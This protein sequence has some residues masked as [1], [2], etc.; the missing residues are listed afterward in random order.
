MKRICFILAFI[1]FSLQ[2]WAQFPPRLEDHFWRRKVVNR[3]DLEEKV[4]KPLV[5]QESGYYRGSEDDSEYAGKDG[6]ISALFSGLK[7]TKYM[8]YDPDTLS[9]PLSYQDVIERINR[10]NAEASAE[11]ALEEEGELDL[12]LEGD[13]G[14]F[15]AFEGEPGNTDAPFDSSDP[16]ADPFGGGN[17]GDPFDPFA[18]PEEDEGVDDL[19]SD[20]TAGGAGIA[21]GSNDL[22]DL[23]PFE[24]VMQFVEDRIF[25]KNRSDM[26]YDI[27]YIEIIWVDVYGRLP[28]RR[29][30]TFRYDDILETLDQV[31]WKN[32]F[33]DAQYRS[34]RQVFEMRLFH[35]YVIDISGVGIQSLAEAE[36]RRQQ[37]VEFEH[38]LW[39]Y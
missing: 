20:S 1:S 26:V 16:F 13:G 7:E 36:Y 38:H 25:D 18:N 32:R 19:G 21:K 29:I 23:Q 10:I 6:I 39:S 27:Q 35:S 14:D 15:N 9:K 28:E 33:N 37:L 12:G 11:G 17:E 34:M 31:Q 5:K 3:I 4:N 8:A 30:A 22:P 2:A 24:M